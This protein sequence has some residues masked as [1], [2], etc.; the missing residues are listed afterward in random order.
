MC[1]SLLQSKQFSCQQAKYIK[2]ELQRYSN[3]LQELS[4]NYWKGREQEFASPLTFTQLIGTAMGSQ[5]ALTSSFISVAKT[6]MNSHNDTSYDSY[7]GNITS[8]STILTLGNFALCNTSLSTPQP[9][10]YPFPAIFPL[11]QPTLRPQVSAHFSFVDLIETMPKLLPH[12]ILTILSGCRITVFQSQHTYDVFRLKEIA[13][14]LTTLCIGG[15]STSHEPLTLNNSSSFNGQI[16]LSTSNSYTGQDASLDVSR[17]LKGLVY[18]GRSSLLDGFLTY[19]K[20]GG[21]FIEE[22]YWNIVL[23]YW[24]LT[25][26]CLA[27]EPTPTTQDKYVVEV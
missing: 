10:E 7:F 18:E 23:D 13:E 27:G 12:L 21:Q 22:R 14:F 25:V 20:E 3:Q 26:R 8:P 9:R 1:I 5:S 11:Y 15:V 4:N 2:D 16:L 24:G 6:L 17:G 19:I